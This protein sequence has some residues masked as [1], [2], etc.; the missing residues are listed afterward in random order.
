MSWIVVVVFFSPGSFFLAYKKSNDLEHPTLPHPSTH[1]PP[2]LTNDHVYPPPLFPLNRTPAQT[3]KHTAISSLQHRDFPNTF[4]V[5][6]P[7]K[8]PSL[9]PTIP[10]NPLHKSYPTTASSLASK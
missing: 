10:A 5:A 1:P 7:T 2:V 6:S 8:K 9:K 4:L 3:A